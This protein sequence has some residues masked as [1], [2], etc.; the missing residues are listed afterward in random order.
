ML[1]NCYHVKNNENKQRKKQ[2]QGKKYSKLTVAYFKNNS[3][4]F[5]CPYF[6]KYGAVYW[7]MNL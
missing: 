7:L 6:K 1:Y 4:F 3:V 2:W 5:Y